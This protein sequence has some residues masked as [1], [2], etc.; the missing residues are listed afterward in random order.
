MRH[1]PNAVI[2]P[3]QII[4]GL[5]QLKSTGIVDLIKSDLHQPNQNGDS[6]ITYVLHGEFD[7]IGGPRWLFHDRRHVAINSMEKR[8]NLAYI[9]NVHSMMGGPRWGNE[10]KSFQSYDS[11]QKIQELPEMNLCNIT[12]K[13]SQV[14]IYHSIYDSFAKLEVMSRIGN[15][16]KYT[17]LVPRNA[18]LLSDL[19]EESGLQVMEYIP[20]KIYRGLM[21]VPSMPG[22]IG[23]TSYSVYDFLRS[24][25]SHIKCA[26]RNRIIY[27][28]RKNS[29]K[30]RI[31]NED[32][33]LRNLKS[34][35][36]FDVLE[37]ENMTISEQIRA[38]KEAKCV[39][40][41][42][43]AGLS[44]IAFMSA[45]NVIEIDSPFYTNGCFKSISRN[46]DRIIHS[47]LKGKQHESADGVSSQ[48]YEV[49]IDEIM[50]KL[51]SLI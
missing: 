34:K 31:L 24:R 48:D 2:D 30:R 43:G 26:E 6:V 42:H 19:L 3:K 47:I 51:D 4:S 29:G 32:E 14:N 46:N 22:A 11:N 15:I 28:T 8:S 18:R 10:L 33:L 9:D 20:N 23:N 37:L 16:E 27:I 40:A 39:I 35:H 17:Y 49:D 25:F 38:F 7:F 41:P 50:H 45:G 44:W 1:M 12:T 21:Y 5:D 36:A 13:W